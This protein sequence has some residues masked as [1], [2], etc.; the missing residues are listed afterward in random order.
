MILIERIKKLFQRKKKI[1]EETRSISYIKNMMI[2]RTN[3]LGFYD[4]KK[5]LDNNDYLYF[6]FYDN[7]SQL[8]L[9]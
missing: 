4:V 3:Q 8:P 9:S 2:I 6:V 1:T 5:Y 7:L